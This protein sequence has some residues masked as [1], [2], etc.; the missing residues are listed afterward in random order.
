MPTPVLT[1]YHLLSNERF[2]SAFPLRE[3]P[4][5]TDFAHHFSE[6]PWHKYNH[7]R[8]RHEDNQRCSQKCCLP[9]DISIMICDYLKYRHPFSVST[10]IADIRILGCW[11]LQTDLFNPQRN[12]P[13]YFYQYQ[14]YEV[15]RDAIYPCET[16]GLYPDRFLHTPGPSPQFSWLRLMLTIVFWHKRFPIPQNEKEHFYMECKM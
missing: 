7:L 8:N 14:P 3:N 12:Y 1:S 6:E 13:N 15:W 5:Q 16:E 9:S 11:M 2:V 10:L 4:S